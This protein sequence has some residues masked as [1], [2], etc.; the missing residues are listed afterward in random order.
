MP[1]SCGKHVGDKGDRP[2]LRGACK[3]I[4]TREVGVI[5][6]TLNRV[7]Y[8]GW[9]SSQRVK[10]LGIVKIMPENVLQRC[11]VGEQHSR[12][13]LGTSTIASFPPAW[14]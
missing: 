9:F 3:I 5:E 10:T 14:I 13:F 11:H 1:R 4:V 12:I 6:V 7:I 8:R 2:C